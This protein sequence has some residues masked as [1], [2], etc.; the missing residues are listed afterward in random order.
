MGQLLYV[1]VSV[2]ISLLCI[3]VFGGDKREREQK[4]KRGFSVERQGTPRSIQ[5]EP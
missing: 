4:Q 3:V 5:G 2:L 1:M